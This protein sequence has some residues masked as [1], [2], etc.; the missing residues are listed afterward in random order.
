MHADHS[1]AGI[2]TPKYYDSDLFKGIQSAFE[3][4]AQSTRVILC[5]I[6]LIGLGYPHLA[7]ALGDEVTKQ[8][9][10][11]RALAKGGAL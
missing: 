4:D 11:L 6:E 10:N 7:K 1:K 2:H 9:I 3:L 5:Y 8:A